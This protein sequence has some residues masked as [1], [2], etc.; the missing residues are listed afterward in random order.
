MEL[1]SCAFVC[2]VFINPSHLTTHAQ[3]AQI[4]LTSVHVIC[5]D[6]VQCALERIG[7]LFNA[8][9]VLI[10]FLNALW[11]VLAYCEEK[12]FELDY[13]TLKSAKIIIGGIGSLFGK[14]EDGDAEGLPNT[15]KV[16]CP[17][18][19]VSSLQRFS[20]CKKC[21]TK[22]IRNDEKQL[23]KCAECG[24]AQLF[25]KCQQRLIANVMFLKAGNTISHCIIFTQVK[26]LEVPRKALNR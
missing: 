21:Q 12:R 1:W 25:H 8:C 7:I 2:A 23:V 11:N 3:S 17:A 10:L 14:R 6:I 24:L 19:G 20:S 4:C 18:E 26:S 9:S 22:L 15:E 5:A 13:K 16:E